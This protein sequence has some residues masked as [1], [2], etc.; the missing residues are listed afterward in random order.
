MTTPS[1]ANPADTAPDGK[2]VL[3]KNQYGKAGNHVVRITRD[4]ARHEIED[5]TVISQLRGDFESC[6]TEGD[7]SHCV[8]T[9]TQKNTIFSLARDGVGSPE[10]F[11]LRL[12][13]HF[14]TSFEWVSGGRW[15]AEQFTWQRIKVDGKEHN[16]AFVQNRT[17][18]RTAVLLIDKDGPHLFA[19]LKDLTVLKSTGSEFHGFPQD[20]YTTLVETSD[21]ILSTD[22]AAR[23]RYNTAELDFNAVY[24]DV[25]RILLETFASVHSLALQQTL[26]QMGKNV[27][28][29]HRNIVDIRFS[30]PNKHHFVVDLAHFGQDN[31]NVVFWAAD[32]PF[33]LIEGTVKRDDAA[34]DLWESV[35]GFC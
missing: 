34:D 28:Q 12:G 26:F 5:L 25:R 22:V 1:G 3:G 16:H 21:R 18:T 2:I 29:A 11:L 27:L 19:G 8:A 7:N 31:P 10:A 23:W 13:K 6:H 32:R 4:T 15:A 9:D 30:M 35:A 20:K 33:G 14:T 24:A 17:E